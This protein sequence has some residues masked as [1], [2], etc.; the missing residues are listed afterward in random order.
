MEIM[1]RAQDQTQNRLVSGLKLIIGGVKLDISDTRTGH[2][3]PILLLTSS[4]K[5]VKFYLQRFQKLIPF[6]QQF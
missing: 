2:R 1:L 4:R 3:Y 5:N 6:S